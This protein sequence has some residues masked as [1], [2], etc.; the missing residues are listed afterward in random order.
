M[1]G[2]VFM[3]LQFS[4]ENF[5][6][7]KEK[8]VLSFFA[9]S[10]SLHPENYSLLGKDKCLKSAAIY[11]A[12]A[13]GKSNLFL[14]LTVAI[15]A[16]RQSNDRQLGMP[17]FNI[18]P[19]L[20]D[21]ETAS[22][23]S[24]FEFIFWTEGVKYVYGF[25]ATS[26]TVETEY[27][28]AYKTAKPTTIFERDIHDTPEYRFTLPSLKKQ[29][30]PIT[31]R[32]TPNKL[33]LA[34]ATLWN[35]EETKAP[36]LWFQKGINTYSTDYSSLLQFSG[37]MFANDADNS[38]RHFTNDLLREADINIS[39]YDFE[40]VD[41][42]KEDVLRQMPS[43]VRELFSSI[44]LDYGKNYN[45]TTL[46]RIQGSDGDSLFSLPLNME[47]K[48]TR[49]VFLLSPILKKAFKTGETVCIDEF[50]TSLH[51]LLVRYLVGLFHN[52]NINTANAQLIISTHD[53]SLLTL[54][55]YRRDQ[56]Y[57]IQK[58][59]ETGASELYSLD[60]YSPRAN[61]DIRKAYLLGRFGAVPNTGEGDLSWE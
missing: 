42:R 36:L 25:S 29:L 55:E 3:L 28:Y 7:I 59:Q 1:K 41:V 46:H 32:N 31:E 53:L 33:F 50:D 38:L 45:I 34:T 49:N 23:P 48:G 19:F 56:I 4:V 61:E 54:K 27:L 15:L 12:N 60:E 21:S 20:F 11:G 30:L 2:A 47:S 39:D 52:P 57:F 6:S 37:E 26:T 44:P 9:S 22:A 51:P 58:D 24:S 14:A 10:D 13:S 8:A 40:S 43:G 17:I 16:V 18:T 5:R 35:C